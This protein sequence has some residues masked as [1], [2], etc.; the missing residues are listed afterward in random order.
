MGQEADGQRKQACRGDV[1]PSAEGCRGQEWQQQKGR[2]TQGETVRQVEGIGRVPK[3]LA[4]NRA[5]RAKKRPC[6]DD[7]RGGDARGEKAGEVKWREGDEE[8]KAESQCRGTEDGMGVGP[9][10]CP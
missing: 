7:Q 3:Q 8:G 9:T 5:G 1:D 4:W 2:R 10:A 6:R